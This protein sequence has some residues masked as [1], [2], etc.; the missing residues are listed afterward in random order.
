MKF[1]QDF[2]KNSQYRQNLLKTDF[3]IFSKHSH[4]NINK[5]FL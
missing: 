5:N 1:L 2:S 4:Q 3:T